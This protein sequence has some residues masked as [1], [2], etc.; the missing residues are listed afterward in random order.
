MTLL[1]GGE[2]A[3]TAV[4]GSLLLHH[5]ALV[6]ELL[7][8]TAERLLGDLENVEQLG[9]LHA[10][11]AIDE[12]QHAVVR[13]PEA[14]FREHVVGIAGEIAIGEE[15]QLDHVPGGLARAAR[16]LAACGRPVDDI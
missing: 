8:D 2:Q 11:I 6:D 1:S 12:M 10:G 9:N 3:L 5:V 16:A 13:A 4:V 14:E 7:E 15:Q